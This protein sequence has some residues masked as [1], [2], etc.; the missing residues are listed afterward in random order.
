[1]KLPHDASDSGSRDADL[2]RAAQDDARAL[3]G[4][5][6][7]R[8]APIGAI[9]FPGYVVEAEIH[10]GG[11]G[12]VFRARQEGTG[13]P[14]AIKL[15][16]GGPFAGDRE[17]VRF[18]REA[19]ILARLKH[20]NI[21]AIHHTGQS[22]EAGG[23]A[24]FVMDHVD[25]RHLD[26]YVEET[27]LAPR[28]VVVLFEKICDAVHAA[29]L[30]GVIHRDLKPSNIR[31]DA[32]GE[33][34]VLDF[35]LAKS[36]SALPD[37][38]PPVT[39]PGQFI[40]S[41]PF[42]SPEQ[43]AGD[44]G[45][46]D[47]RTDVYAIGV[48]LYVCLTGAH[49]Y[50]VSGPLK[51]SLDNILNAAPAP[52]ARLR[53][54]VDDDVASIVLRCLEKD[55]RR[56]YQGAGEVA[57]DLRRFL[58][59]EPVDAKRDRA[60]YVISRTLSRYRMQVGLALGFVGVIAAGLVTALLLWSVAARER[61]AAYEAGLAAD[62]AR[63]AAERKQQDLARQLY[64]HRLLAAQ[65]ALDD[66]NVARVRELLDES[67]AELRGWEWRHLAWMADRSARTFV[68]G[69]P[70]LC[71]DVSPGNDRIAAGDADGALHVWNAMSGAV[72]D[73]RPRHDG[74]I[75]G[76]RFG[77]G[78]LVATAG[79]DGVVRVTDAVRDVTLPGAGSEVRCVTFTNDGGVVAG[80]DGGRGFR[81]DVATS[82]E[83]ARRELGGSI[84]SIVSHAM[85]N[86][87]LAAGRDGA[88]FALD[89]ATLEVRREVARLDAGVTSLALHE[90]S[91][92]LAAGMVNGTAAIIDLPSGAERGRV[93]AHGEWVHAVSLSADGLFLLTAGADHTVMAWNVRT[94]DRDRT[95]RGPT[96]RVFGV[97]FLADGRSVV[98]ASLDGTVRL[99]DR[100]AADRAR[101]FQSHDGQV[102]CADFVDAG[103]T[104][105]AGGSDGRLRRFD[106]RDV[107]GVPLARRAHDG[108]VT[109]LVV[110]RAEEVVVAAGADGRVKRFRL[111]EL[112]PDGELF[113]GGAWIHALALSPDG[114]TVAVASHD[115]TVHLVAARDDG[116]PPR[117]LATLERRP[118]AI[119]FARGGQEIVVGDAAGRLV[120]LDASRGVT[121]SIDPVHDG[122]I[123]SLAVAPDGATVA[124]ASA[125]GTAT[126]ISLD[127]RRV[128]H[129]LRGHRNGVRCV[130]FS[131]DGRRLATGSWDHTI[132]IWDV[133][134]GE[135]ALTVLGHDRRID[136]VRFAPD[137]ERLLSSDIHGTL[138]LWETEPRSKE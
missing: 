79:E 2:I 16:H 117:L 125:D 89:A 44:G 97:R 127:D 34:H 18:E 95:Y 118:Y 92:T 68:A 137:G 37:R 112:R 75:H 46:V 26:R 84:L 52:P 85:T 111:P 102:W 49:P 123:W 114:G 88:V 133:E 39:D 87:V 101:V 110:D 120:R 72:L 55:P 98:C 64:F 45:A 70:L 105:V 109:S 42:A 106:T 29:H 43:A 67:P 66:G 8:R 4:A 47:L 121:R 76:V 74:A 50:D 24:Y 134:H 25:G 56:R 17:R 1:M 100:D 115:S 40:G 126:I 57:R 113:A 13:R 30:H 77:P 35:G 129:R 5:G 108:A 53:P 128:L 19:Q 104:F 36:T 130:A 23:G 41:L 27:R 12:V 138:R 62:A 78:E 15:L 69:R 107:T 11:Q 131:P 3:R 82:R 135:H 31:V 122:V 80:D 14:V 10:R 136:S 86:E 132:K 65:V 83:L 54:D 60:L 96:D 48:M 59:G 20:P 71:V 81:W 73:A 103:R 91:G 94:L 32:R 63:A 28:A 93:R 21:V 124:T 7:E 119:G 51:R 9:R 90:S 22:G 61:D 33:P 6:N 38:T 99:F 58:D 116:A